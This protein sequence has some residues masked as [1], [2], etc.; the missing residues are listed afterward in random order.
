MFIVLRKYCITKISTSKHSE[1][2]NKYGLK[3]ADNKLKHITIGKK[4]NAMLKYV[5]YKIEIYS[6]TRRPISKT[7]PSIRSTNI[8]RINRAITITDR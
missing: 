3:P 2:M 7:K 1:K 8:L 5:K 4:I 6:F